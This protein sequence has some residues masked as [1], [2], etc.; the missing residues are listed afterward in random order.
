MNMDG[1]AASVSTAGGPRYVN[2]DGSARHVSNVEGIRFANMDRYPCSHIEDPPH[3][4][5]E[6]RCRPCSHIEDPPHGLHLL[7]SRVFGGV[8]S[9]VEEP[10]C[11]LA[12]VAEQLQGAFVYVSR[13]THCLWNKTLRLLSAPLQKKCSNPFFYK[14][15]RASSHHA[16][17]KLVERG[18]PSELNPNCCCHPSKAVSALSSAVPGR[19]APWWGCSRSR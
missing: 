4:L 17:R 13:S 2:M 14:L 11:H 15:L 9:Q 6:M 1:S 3:G 10:C 18:H 7:R 16:I 19:V 8:W 12:L 5:H